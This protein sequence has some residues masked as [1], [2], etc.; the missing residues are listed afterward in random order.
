MA[1][2]KTRFYSEKDIYRFILRKRIPYPVRAYRCEK[3]KGWHF[4]SQ[5]ASVIGK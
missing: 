3:C 5:R 2:E 1:C 4:T